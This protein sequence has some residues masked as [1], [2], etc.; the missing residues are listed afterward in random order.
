MSEGVQGAVLK[1]CP[2]CGGSD[3]DPEGWLSEEED[4]VTGD[5]VRR[6]PECLSCGATTRSFEAWNRRVP[7]PDAWKQ[8]VRTIYDRAL[9]LAADGPVAGRNIARGLIMFIEHQHPG[10]FDA[11]QP[12]QAPACSEGAEDPG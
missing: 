4:P 2:F 10:F 5:A 6:G 7:D 11:A 3:V 9:R 12:L 1:A 8:T